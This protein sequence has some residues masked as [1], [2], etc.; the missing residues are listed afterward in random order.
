MNTDLNWSFKIPGTKD[1]VNDLKSCLCNKNPPPI[2]VTQD[3]KAV[4]LYH[5]TPI[6]M[7][8]IKQIIPGAGEDEEQ[9]DSHRLLVRTQ[10]C[11]ATREKWFAGF[12]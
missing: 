5:Y 12:S 3:D 1:S 8:K 4:S 7:A 10:N 11:T 2:T 6:R 9:L